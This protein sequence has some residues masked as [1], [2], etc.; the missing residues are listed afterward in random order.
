MITFTS[1]PVVAIGQKITSADQNLRVA[2]MNG[3]LRSGLGDGPWRIHHKAHSLVRQPLNPEDLDYPSAAAWWEYLGL[4]KPADDLD[5][6]SSGGNLVNPLLQ[7][8][9]GVANVDDEQ[10]RLAAVPMAEFTDLLAAWELGKAQRGAYN[11]DDGVITAPAVQTAVQHYTVAG[12]ELVQPGSVYLKTWGGRQPTAPVVSCPS[13]SRA[14]AG[15]AYGPDEAPQV[16]FYPRRPGLDTNVAADLVSGNPASRIYW[17]C[18]YATDGGYEELIQAQARTDGITLGPRSWLV[19]VPESYVFNPTTSG[20]IAAGVHYR[21]ENGDGLIYNGVTLFSG[22][23]FTGVGGVTTFTQVDA[24]EP[25]EVHK[26]VIEARVDELFFADWFQGPYTSGPVLDQN[27]SRGL[28][29]MISEFIGAFRGTA[30]QRQAAAGRLQTLAFD[31]Q[32]FLESQYQLA[33]AYGHTVEGAAVGDYPQAFFNDDNS[34]S[35]SAYARTTLGGGVDFTATIH[36][37]FTLAGFLVQATTITAELA[38]GPVKLEAFDPSNGEVFSRFTVLSGSVRAHW[39][40]NWETEPTAVQFRMVG[41]TLLDAGEFITI[42]LA[43]LVRQQPTL[44]DA[45]LVLRLGSTRG[46]EVDDTRGATCSTAARISAEFL[47]RGAVCNLQTV[48][49]ASLTANPLYQAAREMIVNRLRMVRRQPWQSQEVVDGKTVLRFDRFTTISGINLDLFE[50][51]APPVDPIET[52]S[53]LSGVVYA[54]ADADINYLGVVYHAGET[55]TG[56]AGNDGFSGEGTVRQVNGIVA[57][58]PA[59]GLSNEWLMHMSLNPYSSNEASV[60]KDDVYGDALTYQHNRALFYS[61]HVTTPDDD[62][63]TLRAAVDPTYRAGVSGIFDPVLVVEAPSAYNYFRSRSGAGNANT[64]AGEGTDT[65]QQ[66]YRSCP[67]HKP[68]YE[69]ESATLEDDGATVVLTLKTRL[70]RISDED[71]GEGFTYRTDENA[72]EDY[73]AALLGTPAPWR[74]GDGSSDWLFSP[75]EG[76]LRGCCQPRFYFTK[77]AETVFEDSPANTRWNSED[78][79]IAA[80]QLRTMNFYLAAMCEGWVDAAANTP[81][82]CDLLAD[83]TWANLCCQVHGGPFLNETPGGHWFGLLESRARLD[84][85]E[86]FGP[87]AVNRLYAENFN[88]ISK[89]L[90]LLTRV[91]VEVPII[92]EHRVKKTAGNNPIEP[93]DTNFPDLAD[94]IAFDASGDEG[95]VEYYPSGN[96]G[97]DNQATATLDFQPATTGRY[98]N[99]DGVSFDHGA[100][101]AW[102]GGTTFSWGG[103]TTGLMLSA[104]GMLGAPYNVVGS[105]DSYEGLD[106]QSRDTG[107]PGPNVVL[108]VGFIYSDG[109]WL[110]NLVATKMTAQIRI[111]NRLGDNAIPSDLLAHLHAVGVVHCRI[112]QITSFYTDETIDGTKLDHAN[113]AWTRTVGDHLVLHEISTTA[114]VPLDL[115]L[116]NN[117][118]SNVVTLEDQS[119]NDL[120]G[121]FNL[122]TSIVARHAGQNSITP[123]P[124][125]AGPSIRRTVNAV[126]SDHIVTIPLI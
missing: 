4:I 107:T 15:T 92:L 97:I 87:Y 106:Q 30:T 93:L 22:N 14:S 64:M 7:F 41:E 61:G 45:M 81:D 74:I 84:G 52:G 85:A 27:P 6:W 42:E 58:A 69:I 104:G 23:G 18:G 60:F 59:N 110:L 83:Y 53:I 29:E 73:A 50:G 55:F 12:N 100:F 125:Y 122:E 115:S 39:S 28:E 89:A 43:E 21:V 3:R 13:Y 33:P 71:L 24:G 124:S 76:G 36:E 25:S 11:P 79:L 67:V 1:A 82:Q 68:D 105:T 119:V 10:T 103:G 16:T 31:F 2:A 94:M 75:P 108:D 65:I 47:S 117:G 109:D 5:D 91:R 95:V 49:I 98:D 72:L 54:V 9:Y 116:F 35:G 44:D 120:L 102:V 57:T 63:L 8:V 118:V 70:Q 111:A 20:S 99:S 46:D 56:V 62:C 19:S 66:F 121:P 96:S 40:R 123:V 77:L 38:S 78:S 101:D 86:G 17:G 32:I 126:N 90:N 114:C 34:P 113:A 88:N 26:V 37:G 48:G 51:I 80:D 112:N